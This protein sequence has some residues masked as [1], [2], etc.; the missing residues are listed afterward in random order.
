[1]PKHPQSHEFVIGGVAACGA[2]LFTN[3]LEVVKTRMQLQGELQARGQFQV[4]YR[5][6]F[7]A[8]FTIARHEGICALQKGISPA[9]LYQFVMNGFRLGSF[10]LLNDSRIFK[11]KN[12]QTPF[13]GSVACGAVAGSMGGFF[14]SP[15]Y[16][17][18][19]LYS[20]CY[21]LFSTIFESSST[22]W[23]WLEETKN[24]QIITPLY[25]S[26]L[27]AKLGMGA[28]LIK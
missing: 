17:V 6:V 22:S 11:D 10:Q 24:K 7:H 8:F 12:G 4:H 13:I 25:R 21:S 14:G 27:L 16:M 15:I 1:M 3:P 5:N 28:A 20:L 9:L 19:L 26:V 2:A 18:C 23:T